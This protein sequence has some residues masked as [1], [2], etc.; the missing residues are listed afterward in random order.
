M[1]SAK[2]PDQTTPPIQRVERFSRHAGHSPP[3]TAEVKNEWRYT[4]TPSNA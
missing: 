3:T 1:S 2:R 4:C